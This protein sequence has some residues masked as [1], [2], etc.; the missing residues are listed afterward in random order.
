[1]NLLFYL[2]I[3]F[4][5]DVYHLKADLLVSSCLNTRKYCFIYYICKYKMPKNLVKSLKE[6]GKNS[7]TTCT[8][9]FYYTFF[10]IFF[11]SDFTSFLKTYFFLILGIVTEVPKCPMVILSKI[12]HQILANCQG[13]I[14]TEHQRSYPEHKSNIQLSRYVIIFGNILYI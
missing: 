12:I 9:I 7:A 11:L 5:L 2:I 10:S 3:F 13:N 6:N 14:Q 8:R 4:I 1:M